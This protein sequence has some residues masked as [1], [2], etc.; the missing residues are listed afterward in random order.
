MRRL[1]YILILVLLISGVFLTAYSPD[2][3]STVFTV[4]M[5]I[6]M[7]IGIVFGI[8]PVLQYAAA[9]QNGSDNIDR[10]LESQAVSVW[11]GVS[12]TEEFFHQRTMDE[13]LD[14]YKEKIKLQQQSAQILSDV[15][16]YINDDVLAMRSWQNLVHQVPGTLTGLGILG[17]FVGLIIGIRG[18]GFSTINAALNSVQ[19]M[20]NGIQV[21]F[22]TSIS[23]V[24]LSLLFNLL[25]RISWN[26][27]LRNMA[28]FSDKFH[29]HVIP[30]VEE[31]MRYRER[32][33]FKEIT[34]LLERLPKNAGFSVAGGG[35][36]SAGAGGGNEQILMPQILEGLKNGEF[37]FQLQPKFDLN[38]RKVIGSEALVRW[39]HGKLG[40]VSPAVFIPVLE[41]NGYI[42]KLDQYIWEQVCITL[43]QW[44]DK[45]ARP[46]PI[47]INVT[48]TDVLAM[49]IAEFFMNMVKKYRIPPRTLQIEIAENAYLQC[50]SA[51]IEA[52]ETLRQAGFR[53]IVDGFNGDYMALSTVQNLAADT[54]KLDLRHFPGSQNQG[55][56][57]AVFDQARKLDHDLAVEGVENM[58]QLGMLRKCGCSEGQGFFLSKPVSL[59]QFEELVNGDSKK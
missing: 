3:I 4:V 54:L 13:L 34:E 12:Q 41:N 28:M 50:G 51:V 17:T 19:T 47:A 45:G 42:T 43:R 40:M 44:I 26:I 20:L 58:E 15:D 25:Y 1:T 6:V 30:P 29:K 36:V 53:V 7:V 8:L 46:M 24:I 31:Q 14:D 11:S 35:G 23:G 21:A 27:M 52:E 16:D 55:S 9:F 10:I 22:Y 59:E 49:D 5:E 57:S 39:K 18:I 56:L 2:D 48:K 33:D 38:T 32:K 37:I